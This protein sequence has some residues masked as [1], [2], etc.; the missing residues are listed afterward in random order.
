MDDI[1][2][3]CKNKEQATERLKKITNYLEENLKLTL[4]YESLDS[5]YMASNYITYENEYYSCSSKV[6][7]TIYTKVAEY[8]EMHPNIVTAMEYELD[9]SIS[10]YLQEEYGINEVYNVYYSGYENGIVRDAYL[11]EE[12]KEFILFE[13]AEIFVGYAE[14]IKS[15]MEERE[16]NIQRYNRYDYG[17][18]S[19]YVSKELVQN[20]GIIEE[21]QEEK[22]EQKG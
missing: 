13:D 15:L 21:L 7:N 18:Y 19:I 16:V 3:L 20:L 9:N 14:K 4:N 11:A 2:I 5:I 1:V 12:D 8:K 10:I 17:M 6:H 22:E